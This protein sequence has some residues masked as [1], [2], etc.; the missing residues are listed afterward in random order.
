MTATTSARP[1][2]RFGYT[3][4]ASESFDDLLDAAAQAA[5]GADAQHAR[6]PQQVVEAALRGGLVLLQARAGAGKSRF[7]QRLQETAQAD[8]VTVASVDLGAVR[9]VPM[10]P[11]QAARQMLEHA[12]TGLAALSGQPV[13]ILLDG[14]N[15]AP[16]G[17]A[18]VVLEAAERLASRYPRHRCGRSR[19]AHPAA[20]GRQRPV[21]AAGAYRGPRQ[22]HHLLARASPDGGRAD[23]ARHPPS[24][25]TGRT[26]PARRAVGQGSS[27]SCS[28][29][30]CPRPTSTR[31][32]APPCA[33]IA[34]DVASCSPRKT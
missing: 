21:A 32:R 29:M 3:A 10:D 9:E 18:P 22:R 26:R 11:D 13:L 1:A 16:G 4:Y 23:P 33:P 19:P 31:W 25:S 14:L 12:G 28:P 34:V 15:E 24:T 6:P 5:A 27:E 7:M 8:G 30:R 20:R 17:S 2:S